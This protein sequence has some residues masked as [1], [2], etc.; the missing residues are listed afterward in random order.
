MANAARQI[1]ER[2]QQKYPESAVSGRSKHSITHE[3]SPGRFVS[4]SV[5]SALHYGEF[6][7][8]EIDTDW[9]ISALQPWLWQMIRAGYNAYAMPGN[10]SFRSGQIVKYTHPETGSEITFQPQQLQWTNSL[11]QIMP[12]ADV[13]DV[14]GVVSGD[15]VT[16]SGAYGPNTSFVW[17]CQ[18]ERLQKRLIIDGGLPPATIDPNGL[19]LK[20][21]FIIGKSANV[22]IWIYTNVGNGP[23]WIM[24]NE[25]NKT[26]LDT[27]HA[28]QFRDKVSQEVLWYF[29]PADV[30]DQSGIRDRQITVTTRV[31]STARSVFV[32]I[33][34]P[35]SWLASAVGSVTIDPTISPTVSSDAND[36]LVYDGTNY[37]TSYNQWF[38]G[39]D[40]DQLESFAYFPVTLPANSVIDEALL[41]MRGWEDKSGSNCNTRFYFEDAA[42]PSAPTSASDFNGRTRTSAYVDWLN[43]PA[44][45]DSGYYDSPDLS[46]IVQELVD[47]Y[48]YS[49]GANMGLMLDYISAS[50]ERQAIDYHYE[51]AAWCNVLYIDYHVAAASSPKVL[52]II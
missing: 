35:E 32:E 23:E 27:D 2:I 33:L 28:I 49:S 19:V 13:A 4:V 45:V 39:N 10:A 17:T 15:T 26:S 12:V 36:G 8:I 52:M 48:S 44:F 18:N 38:I 25:K 50:S 37:S 3:V 24:H 20:A 46:S 14:P 16:W 21:Q 42:N 6:S 51:G 31:R 7:D 1:S 34:V 41:Q 5:P 43:I 47:S 11:S 9:E 40:G 29:E 30:Y 22:E